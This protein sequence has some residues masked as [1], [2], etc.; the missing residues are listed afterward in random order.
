M[1]VGY[2]DTSD[3]YSIFIRAQRKTIVRRD[4][5]FEERLASRK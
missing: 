1:F 4:V 5:K 2:N 3:A